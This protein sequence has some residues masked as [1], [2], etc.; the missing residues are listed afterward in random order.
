MKQDFSHIK[1]LGIGI[2][3]RPELKSFI[4]LNRDKIDFIEIDTQGNDFNVL[5]SFGDK[6]SII[7]EGVVE[8]SNNVDLYKGV[9][10]RIENIREFLETNGFQIVSE[11]ENDYLKAE[12]N[13]HFVKNNL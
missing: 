11:N 4:F 1:A 6:I 12:I 9:N 2:G 8:A 5:K 7:K 3:F 13:I 10:N